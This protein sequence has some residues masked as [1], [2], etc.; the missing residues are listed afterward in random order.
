MDLEEGGPERFEGRGQPGAG[1][2][3]RAFYWLLAVLG[4]GLLLAS[5][6]G[7]PLAV[8]STVN[9]WST[10]VDV[11]IEPVEAVDVTIR[12]SARGRERTIHLDSVGGRSFDPPFGSKSPQGAV[13]L[14]SL[15]GSV[16]VAARDDDTRNVLA[17]A[18]IAKLALA[19][20]V[21]I[22]LERLVESA[23]AGNPFDRR[24][25]RR[26]RFVGA[27]V[28]AYPVGADV[29]RRILQHTLEADLP[30]RVRVDVLG[31]WPCVTIAVG[32]FALAEVF[33]RGA[34]LREFEEFTV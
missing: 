31:F 10:H 21:V 26:L 33:R 12:P 4:L 18:F 6:F 17:L 27:A 29:V 25:L 23:K 3:L 22:N 32:M 14:H 5:G 11:T 28:L 8:I 15:R 1:R 30:V 9:D 34:E 20:V 13:V 24:N 19:W 16:D 7:V 2:A